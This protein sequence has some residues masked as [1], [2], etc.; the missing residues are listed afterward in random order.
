MSKILGKLMSVTIG[1]TEV[2]IQSHS[3]DESF[4][5]IDTTDTATTGDGTESITG[6]A[7][8]ELKLE[9]LVKSTGSAVKG[10][11]AD[12]TFN[13]VNYKVTDVNFEET[14]GEVDTT[15][16]GTT[17]DGT[18]FQPAFAERKTSID[19]WI[20]DNVAS[21][22]RGTAQ[23]ATLKLAT[24]IT[25]AGSFRPES[26]SNQGEVKGAQKQTIAGTWQGAVTETPNP[27]GGVTMATPAAVVIVYRTG[28]PTTGTD[29]KLSGTATVFSR[30]I[31]S[32]MNDVVKISFGLKFTGA[33]TETQ[34]S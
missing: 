8:R 33:V 24:G 6:R 16:T 1:G 15:D 13:S 10:D 22:V 9:G 21:I 26:M 18:E 12:F 11:T 20:Q 2:D 28:T 17:G 14:Y 23:T 4:N 7:T 30:S 34:W 29:K 5:V 32:N 3:Y 27:I 19:L 31:T 25:V